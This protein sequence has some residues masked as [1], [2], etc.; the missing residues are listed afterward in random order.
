MTQHKIVK[1]PDWVTP[2][3]QDYLSEI[4]KEGWELVHVYNQ[5]A[6]MKASSGVGTFVS[7]NLATNMDAFGRLRV[8]DTYTLGDYKH[9]YAVDYNFEDYFVSGGSTTF[10]VN[11]ASVTLVTSA[12]AASRA[13]H[14]TKMYHNYMPGKSQ[15]IMSSFNFGAPVSGTIKRTGYFDD[16]NGIFLEQDQTGSLQFV[17]R[18]ATNGTAS[19]QENRVKQ[20]NWNVNTLLSG[21]VVLDITKAQLFWIDFQWLA[22]GRVRC[23]F[24]INGSQILCHVFDH[25]NKTT[26]AYMS[27]PNLPVRCEIRNTTTATGSMEQ[28]CATVMS[29]GGYEESGTTYAHTS[30][31]LRTI[32]GS[33]TAL[34][35]AIRLKNSYNGLPNRAFVRLEDTSVFSKDQ[36]VKYVVV[37]LESGSVTGGSWFS[38][39]S[40][41]VVE[42]NSGSMAYDATRTH[43]MLNGFVAAGTAGAGGGP[44]TGFSSTSQRQGSKNKI[45]YIAQNYDSTSSEMYGIIVTNL[46]GTNTDVIASMVWKEVY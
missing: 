9:L 38:E 34:I 36:T 16:Y 21:D 7:G 29:E 43:E 44:G 11:R 14:Q 20:E 46:T 30:N 1:I 32:S 10:N 6:Y 5:H 19:L 39:D 42:W 12:S 18:S 15:Y 40:G 3:S 22:V 31:T 37:K 35:M 4:G 2:E 27:T 26:G 28:I 23:G 41:S 8:T 45:N 33:Q 17:V 25:S 24:V 13:V